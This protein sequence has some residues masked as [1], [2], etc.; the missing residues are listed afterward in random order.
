MDFNRHL[1]SGG[2][3][4]DDSQR[5]RFENHFGMDLG[6]V[7]L[8]KDRDS[9]F[10]SAAL[11]AHAFAYKEHIWLG[12]DASVDDTELMRHELGHVVNNHPG[13]QLREA[14]YLERRAWLSFFDHYLPRKFLNNYMNDTGDR[15]TLD[16]QE[17]EDCNPIVDLRRSRRFTAALSRLQ[18][19]NGGV[20][21]LDITGWGGAL[22]NGTLGNFT[23]HYAGTL[24]VNA[25]G[26][27]LFFGT[28]WFEDYWDFNTGG[29]NR[30][31]AAEIKVRFANLLLPGRPFP[32]D[33]AVVP[34]FQSDSSTRAQWGTAAPPIHVP[35]RAGTTGADIEVGAG[36]GETAG[37]AGGLEVEAGGG[38]GG[39]EVGAQSSED[40]N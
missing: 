11:Q 15:I 34:V 17:M 30:P 22:T 26:T 9:A 21:F 35:D 6:H 3:A 39:G 29:A 25:D 38:A 1:R 23:I 33:S 40:V 36:G 12:S 16:M 4:L 5:S 20:E 31:I 28:L 24:T 14:T 32:I 18:S 13:I 19:A 27:W 7:R 2:K 10:Y 37:A 8:H